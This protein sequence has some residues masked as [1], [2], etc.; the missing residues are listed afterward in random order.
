[1]LKCRLVGEAVD[2]VEGVLS[3][4]GESARGSMDLVKLVECRG[5]AILGWRMMMPGL[6]RVKG[7]CGKAAE[8]RLGTLGRG[9]L[10]SA[11]VKASCCSKC[12]VSDCLVVAYSDSKS[13]V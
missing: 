7:F 11:T 2:G 6:G 12:F 8:D 5:A 9:D 13:F 10:C 4:A 3:V 1:M